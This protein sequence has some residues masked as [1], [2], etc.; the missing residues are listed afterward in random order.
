MKTPTAR[1]AP[2][3]DPHMTRITAPESSPATLRADKRAMRQVAR[4]RRSKCDPALGVA[5]GERLLAERPPAPGA[6]VAGVW[7][8]PGEIDLRPLL[9]ALAAQGHPVLLPRTLRRGEP[10]EFRLWT[11]GAPLEAGSFGTLHPQGGLPAPPPDVI[12]VPLLAFD[13][14]GGRLGYGAG[15]YDRTLRLYPRAAAIGFAFAAQEVDAVPMEAHD[16]RLPA[17]ATERGII[18]CGTD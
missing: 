17:I 16:V 5:L 9:T 18:D 6:V 15:F 3:T 1:V 4:A 10:L 14:R 2:H 7:P 8:L 12:L 13:R 11:P